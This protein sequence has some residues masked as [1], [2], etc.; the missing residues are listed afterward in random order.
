MP[1]GQSGRCGWVKVL[2]RLV[3]L[4]GGGN[5]CPQAQTLPWPSRCSPAC[6]DSG[7]DLSSTAQLLCATVRI[8]PSGQLGSAAGAVHSLHNFL[9]EGSDHRGG[10]MDRLETRAAGQAWDPARGTGPTTQT[11]SNLRTGGIHSA[12]AAASPYE[13]SGSLSDEWI[14]E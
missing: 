2:F 9:L 1:E 11:P 7:G 6:S 14:S 3:V 12:P 13:P 8:S 5:P 4:A 10:W